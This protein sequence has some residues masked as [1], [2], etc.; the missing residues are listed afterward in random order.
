MLQTMPR[1]TLIAEKENYRYAEFSSRTM[2]FVDDVEFLL[3]E[4]DGDASSTNILYHREDFSYE[5]R[6]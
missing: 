5:H 1:V 4:K 3:D 6:R 2:G